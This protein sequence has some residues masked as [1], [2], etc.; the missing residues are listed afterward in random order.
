[1]SD[2]ETHDHVAEWNG[3]HS[4]EDRQYRESNAEYLSSDEEDIEEN[5]VWYKD[6]D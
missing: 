3:F 2:V 1:M 4:D 6:N 5:F